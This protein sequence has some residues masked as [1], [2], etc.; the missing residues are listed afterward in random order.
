VL[1]LCF[2]IE[3]IGY[4]S[5]LFSVQ[6]IAVSNGIIELLY[7][8]NYG[9]GPA[10]WVSPCTQAMSRLLA[11]INPAYHGLEPKWWVV[12]IP[13]EQL[14]TVYLSSALCSH[15]TSI[16]RGLRA[17][18]RPRHSLS[19][20]AAVLFAIFMSCRP[21]HTHTHTHTHIML[22]ARLLSFSCV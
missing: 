17:S 19:F 16:D 6:K 11:S 12:Q 2:I 4:H 13:R 10:C 8:R 20:Y 7:D 18:R 21:T 15:V 3:C 22:C 9:A 1:K 14:G 5:S